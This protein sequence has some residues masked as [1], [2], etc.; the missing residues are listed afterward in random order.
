MAAAAERGQHLAELCERDSDVCAGGLCDRLSPCGQ[1][2]GLLLVAAHRGE[3]WAEGVSG[4]F[5]LWFRELLGETSR[6][7]GCGNRNVPIAEAGRHARV[8]SEQPRQMPEPPLRAQPIDRRP[9]EVVAQVESAD[10]KR[11]WA[12]E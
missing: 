6:F 8:Q 7:F 4:G 12:E 1:A 9:K 11:G 10:D 5:P 2:L 3:E